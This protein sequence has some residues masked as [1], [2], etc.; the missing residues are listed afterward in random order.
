MGVAIQCRRE[1][2]PR[3]VP[4][5]TEWGVNRRLKSYQKKWALRINNLYVLATMWEELNSQL[6]QRMSTRNMVP[7]SAYFWSTST[8]DMQ[9]PQFQNK[10]RSGSLR[11]DQLFAPTEEEEQKIERNPAR[12]TQRKLEEV[13]KLEVNVLA[14]KINSGFLQF[15]SVLIGL[16]IPELNER[17]RLAPAL[18]Y[19]GDCLKFLGKYL[20][21][22]VFR[23]LL[24]RIWH[25][26]IKGLECKAEGI[27]K[28]I[29]A[30]LRAGAVAEQYL[31]VLSCLI[32]FFKCT[33]QQA[34]LEPH[35]LME[36]SEFFSYLLHFHMLE[37]MALMRIFNVLMEE[38]SGGYQIEI[39]AESRERRL[40]AS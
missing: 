35:L 4:P 7:S 16:D 40:S 11:E 18:N 19:L 22:D 31:H 20:Y 5:E 13:L 26:V 21:P 34:G 32:N 3:Y 38:V 28:R 24:Q 10:F 25:N 27:L 14:Y 17:Q 12:E 23:Y 2:I 37:A 8:T 36:T 39:R 29:S 6:L 1:N 15:F 33:A 30:P 9:T